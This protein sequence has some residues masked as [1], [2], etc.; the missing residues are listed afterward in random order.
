[1]NINIKE[2]K[3][4]EFKESLSE[5]KEGGKRCVVLQTIRVVFYILE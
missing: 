3:M 1:M 2:S 5:L 4:V